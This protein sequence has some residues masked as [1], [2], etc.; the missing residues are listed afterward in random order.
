MGLTLYL[1][2]PKRAALKGVLAPFKDFWL[3][4]GLIQG[5]LRIEL[6]GLWDVVT[7]YNWAY[8]PT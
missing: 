8:N 3:P 7:T 4:V 5:R 6:G 2:A 1:G